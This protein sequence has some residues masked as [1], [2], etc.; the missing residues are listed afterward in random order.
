MSVP[1]AS[2]SSGYFTLNYPSGVNNDE[3]YLPIIQPTY[4]SSGILGWIG[5]VQPHGN[6]ACYIYVRQGTVTPSNGSKIGFN[7]I[8]IHR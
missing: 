5:T 2:I 4:L 6:A 3:Y 1:E 7:A 8:W